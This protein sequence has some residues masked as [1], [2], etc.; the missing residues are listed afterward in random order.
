[1]GPSWILIT[2]ILSRPHLRQNNVKRLENFNHFSCLFNI[3]ITVPKIIGKFAGKILLFGK[4]T[5][6]FFLIFHGMG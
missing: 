4:L 1:M 2:L 6:I 3:D 5:W